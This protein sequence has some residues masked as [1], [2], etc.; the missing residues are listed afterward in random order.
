MHVT[1][2]TPPSLAPLGSL[3]YRLSANLTQRD[4]CLWRHPNGL[5]GQDRQGAHVLGREPRVFGKDCRLDGRRQFP[6]HD[7]ICGVYGYLTP[8]KEADLRARED[9]YAQ[10]RFE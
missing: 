9:Q 5:T 2:G 6:E 1:L 3:Q 10:T 7:A 8:W 4:S